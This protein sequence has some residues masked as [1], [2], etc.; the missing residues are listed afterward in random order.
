MWKSASFG[1]SIHNALYAFYAVILE[2]TTQKQRSLFE[3]EKKELG[4]TDL[5]GFLDKAWV[6]G[7]Y[8]SKEEEYQKKREGMDM[9]S[10]WYEQNKHDLGVPL[11][12]E[13]SFKLPLRRVLLSGRFDRIDM[14][15]N[16]NVEIIDYKTGREKDQSG[17]DTDLQ[18]SIYAKAASD[19]LGHTVEK[20]CLYY[21]QKNKRI[22]TVRD[23]SSLEEMER[24]VG[25]LAERIE[26]EDWEATPSRETCT[27]CDYSGICPDRA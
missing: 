4:V 21:V 7:G 2:R 6:S 26:A 14:L 22:Y 17:V 15:P 16:G 20:L 24:E 3:E 8:A 10:T 19:V 5:L 18:L 9:L 1:S 13:T 11:Y 12:L 25:L 27:Y 23:Q